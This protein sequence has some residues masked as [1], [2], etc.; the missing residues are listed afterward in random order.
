MHR[1]SFQGCNLV[2][3]EACA[4]PIMQLVFVGRNAQRRRR[5]EDVTV[6]ADRGSGAQPERE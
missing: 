4:A 3:Q 2:P 5:N 6:R 1:Q